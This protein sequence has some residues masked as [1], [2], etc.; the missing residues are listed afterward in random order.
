MPHGPFDCAFILQ[1]GL[2]FPVLTVSSESRV[3]DVCNLA[4]GYI[5]SIAPYQPGKAISELAR[6]SDSTTASSS[7]RRTRIRS[8]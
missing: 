3:S 1:D 4:P 7:L 2:G 5:R 6:G 8:A